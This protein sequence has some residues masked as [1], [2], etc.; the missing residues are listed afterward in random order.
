MNAIRFIG[1]VALAGTLAGCAGT[2]DMATGTGTTTPAPVKTVKKATP[3]IVAPKATRALPERVAA[4]PRYTP[5]PVAPVRSVQ[6]PSIPSMPRYTPEPV[7]VPK[8][9]PTYEP[10][11]TVAVPRPEPRYEPQ[12]EPVE[13]A[14]KP[15][16]E[17]VKTVAEPV[18]EPVRTVAVA[19]V[20]VTRPDPSRYTALG[21]LD[22]RAA[23]APVMAPRSEPS[24]VMAAPMKSAPL[25]R[26]MS[27]IRDDPQDGRNGRRSA[28]AEIRAHA[29]KGY[30]R[31]AAL[32]AG[33]PKPKVRS[34]FTPAFGL[35]LEDAALARLNPRIRYD[36][37]YVKIGY[38]WG[39]VDESTGVCSDVIIRSYRTLGIDLQSLIHE[40]MKRAFRAYPSKR[41][42]GL[43]KADPNIDHRRVVNM[44]A[45]FERTGA[46]IP[47]GTSPEDF[48]P[49]DVLTWRLSG[50][51][52]HVG[53]V[54]SDRDPRSGYPLVVHNLGAGVRKDDLITLSTP[55]GH[56]RFAPDSD[57]VVA[58]L[59]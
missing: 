38:P 17:P 53:I 45:F 52:P 29:R 32:N 12:Y 58:A 46:S 59:R 7:V 14:A 37:R 33:G 25:S 42:Y 21:D 20:A 19:P 57:T 35:K 27:P 15:A 16:Y 50:N 43:K 6:V 1:A 44:E 36:A 56:F 11:E 49:G 34:N 51:E 18:Y 3:P 24:Y 28:N 40:D 54:V 47:I 5:A 13:T 31:N 30:R 10:V 22:A 8:A 41:I 9:T 23:P 55:V 26:S 4:L 2:K 48:Q 39:D